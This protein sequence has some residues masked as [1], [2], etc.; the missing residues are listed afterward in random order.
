MGVWKKAFKVK[1]WNLKPPEFSIKTVKHS[2]F[3]LHSIHQKKLGCSAPDRLQQNLMYHGK[4]MT[5]P[6]SFSKSSCRW[7]KIFVVFNTHSSRHSSLVTFEVIMSTLHTFLL[8]SVA[9]HSEIT[10][11]FCPSECPAECCCDLGVECWMLFW[12]GEWNVIV[13]VRRETFDTRTTI[14]ERVVIGWYQLRQSLQREQVSPKTK[15]RNDG[16]SLRRSLQHSTRSKIKTAFRS[17]TIDNRNEGNRHLA[18][19]RT[20]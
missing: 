4:Y 17:F 1:F 16:T 12:V 10:T 9:F 19:P 7:S 20:D 6:P 5:R 2:S 15:S 18:Q 13:T 3:Y 14:S 8:S 11:T